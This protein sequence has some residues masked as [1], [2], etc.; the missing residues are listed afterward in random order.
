MRRSLTCSSR[1]VNGRYCNAYRYEGAEIDVCDSALDAVLVA[2][3]FA[4]EALDP[5]EKEA[6]FPAMVLADPDGAIAAVGAG[7]FW[8]MLDSVSW[9]AFGLDLLGRRTEQVEEPVFDWAEDAARIR[10]S[11]L[12]AY[13]LSWDEAAPRTGY[14]E[15]CGL[16]A[17]LME[18]GE[19]PL[20][21]AVY[22]RIADRPSET[23]YN[24]AAV[25]AFDARREHYR[26]H[27]RA[28]SPEEEAGCANDAMAS[29]FMG[30]W[31]AAER[32][33]GKG[34]SRGR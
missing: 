13:G 21:Q 25:E 5:A 20:Q 16:L 15:M 31:A 28:A 17:G 34:V 22:Y 26:L 10:A 12:Q 32:A 1:S 23:K 2:E 8:D 11:L 18:A 4:D 3:L 19:T 30:E 9:D 33:A 29:A 14:A 24:R 6:L 7:S 27:R